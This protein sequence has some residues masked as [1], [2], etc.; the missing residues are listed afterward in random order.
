MKVFLA[1][2]CC[3][4]D[5]KILHVLLVKYLYV[6]TRSRLPFCFAVLSW[7]YGKITKNEAYNLL[8]TGNLF[9]FSCHKGYFQKNKSKKKIKKNN[10]IFLSHF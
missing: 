4:Y 3:L 5:L 10:L 7:Y 9:L 8:M 2:C 6:L 1:I